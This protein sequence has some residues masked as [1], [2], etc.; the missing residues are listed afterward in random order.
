MEVRCVPLGAVEG[1]YD[2]SD[3][4]IFQSGDEFVSL[5]AVFDEGLR[6]IFIGSSRK[7]LNNFC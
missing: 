4:D 7:F 5:A 2:E 1:L 3:G 6:C